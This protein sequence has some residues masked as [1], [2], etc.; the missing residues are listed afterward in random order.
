[1]EEEIHSKISTPDYNGQPSMTNT[2]VKYSLRLVAFG[3]PVT[4]SDSICI[5]FAATLKLT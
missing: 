4:H 2:V 3:A 1:M 5:G